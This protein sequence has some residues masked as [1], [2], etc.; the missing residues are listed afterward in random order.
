MV[1]SEAVGKTVAALS[2]KLVPV[3]AFVRE[4]SISE[5]LSGLKPTPAKYV[6]KRVPEPVAELSARTS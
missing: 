6:A 4:E 2:N 1:A 3:G 5:A